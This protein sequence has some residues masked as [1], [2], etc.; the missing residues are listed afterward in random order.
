[1]LTVL[2][3]Y[4]SNFQ[5]IIII[6]II[7]T[8]FLHS[9]LACSQKSTGLTDQAL[10]ICCFAKNFVTVQRVFSTAAAF[11]VRICG[12]VLNFCVICLN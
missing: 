10:C 4:I 6:I 7:T 12:A 5:T 9:S 1:M 2:C 11:C 3:F 8:T